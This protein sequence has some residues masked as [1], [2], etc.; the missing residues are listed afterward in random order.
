MFSGAHGTFVVSIQNASG[1]VAHSICCESCCV[2]QFFLLFF[3]SDVLFTPVNV[4]FPS[5]SPSGRCSM[6]VLEISFLFFAAL[7]HSG[8]LCQGNA[9]SEHEP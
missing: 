5:L 6:N 1:A 8:F 7:R 9:V 3:C 4:P 2:L